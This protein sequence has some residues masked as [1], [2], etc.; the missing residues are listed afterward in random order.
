MKRFGSENSRI[1]E[2]GC[3]ALGN[4]TV[5]V[6]NKNE[7]GQ[8]GACEVIVKILTRFGMESSLVAQYGMWSGLESC[9]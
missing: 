9:F 7:L 4:L 3:A 2:E 1:A 5:D 6:E 8:L